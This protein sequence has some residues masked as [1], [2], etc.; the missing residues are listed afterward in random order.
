MKVYLRGGPS[1]FPEPLRTRSTD[2]AGE[3]ITIQFLNRRGHF[4][5]TDELIECG[6]GHA[7]VYQ[8][9]YQTYIAE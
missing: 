9:S 6:D 4:L 3:K 7:Q 2:A 1:G 5:V 8:W